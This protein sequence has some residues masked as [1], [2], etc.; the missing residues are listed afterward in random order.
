MS[1]A[2]RIYKDMNVAELFDEPGR[3]APAETGDP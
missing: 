3:G 1:Y 2:G